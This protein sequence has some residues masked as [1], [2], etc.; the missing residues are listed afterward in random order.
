MDY[1]SNNTYLSQIIK[2]T[3]SLAK[4]EIEHQNLNGNL[5]LR[6]AILDNLPLSLFLHDIQGNLWYANKKALKMSNIN[7]ENVEKHNFYSL[8]KNL[9]RVL[10][11][12]RI[13]KLIKEGKINFVI[14]NFSDDSKSSLEVEE[15]I[16]ELD[17]QK[18]ILSIVKD[19][20]AT[21][22]SINSYKGH[23][24]SLSPFKM[25][26]GYEKE[27][28]SSHIS[29]KTSKMVRDN[30][31][32]ISSLINLQSRYF[33]D[34]ETVNVFREIQNRVRAITL[35]HEKLRYANDPS[36]IN[37]A[38][39]VRGLV[40]RLFDSYKDI[41]N[42]I[43]LKLNIS[44]VYLDMETLIP[45]GLIINELVTNSIKYAFSKGKGQI[46]VIFDSK[47]DNFSLTVKDNGSGIP[48]DIDFTQTDT[49]GLQL[50]NNLTNQLNGKI[51][52]EK[53]PG[54]TFHITFPKNK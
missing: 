46:K 31:D 2:R 11:K 45:C 8:D 28:E 23:E 6:S 16:I 35:A 4:L 17:N 3:I 13:S 49:L 25:K 18:M 29:P 27:L 34:D 10:H 5:S 47:A 33:Q 51:K 14:D 22:D 53:G 54:T 1:T 44:P 15:K 52:L 9:N 48:N 38:E 32:L 20:E 24:K 36:Q 30:L 43:D 39:Y 19:S 12:E 37:F 21:E 40:R 7:M 50:V 41:I 26:V 42:A